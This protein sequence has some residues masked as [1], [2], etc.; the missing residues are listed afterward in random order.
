[1]TRTLL[2][3][4]AA[5]V[6][7]LVEAA[8]A[9]AAPALVTGSAVYGLSLED[10]SGT[11]G[12]V[13]GSMTAVLTRDCDTY[14]STTSLVADFE[15]P[16]GSLPLDMESD[17]YEKADSLVF[18][19]RGEFASMEI[20]RARGEATRTDGG[21]A[22]ALTEPKTETRTVDGDVIFPLAMM[23]AA[24]A[25]AKAGKTLVDFSVYDGSGHGRDVWLVSVTIGAA[26]ESGD[27][28]GDDA[29]FAAGLGFSGMDRWQ[30]GFSYYPADAT[31]DLTPAFSSSAVVYENGF[32]QAA[33][34]DFGEFALRL[35]LEEFSSIPPEP[36]P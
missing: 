11:M 36:C 24:V 32:A 6:A 23:G 33:S 9:A 15:G 30:M 2:A 34:Y 29:L 28:S 19:I 7:G 17:V 27:E 25:A 10:E 4:A 18:D 20:E 5:G 31:G 13:T 16:M 22:V 35:K 12:G 8:G 3:V 14:R 26:P 21:I 1:M